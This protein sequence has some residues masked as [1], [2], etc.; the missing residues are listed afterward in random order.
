APHR[1]QTT[2]S[3]LSG[4]SVIGRSPASVIQAA[5]GADES[6]DIGGHQL[7]VPSAAD[8]KKPRGDSDVG[9]RAQDPRATRQSIR[10]ADRGRDPRPSELRTAYSGG[11]NRAQRLTARR[12]LVR[13]FA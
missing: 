4:S 7:S 9:G 10:T 1:C 8:R 3:R 11:A 6:G 12:T 13:A 2:V 5:R